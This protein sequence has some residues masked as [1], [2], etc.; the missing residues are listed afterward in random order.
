M[1]IIADGPMVTHLVAGKKCFEKPDMQMIAKG[2]FGLQLHSPGDF[3]A[4]FRNIFVRPL[5]NSFNIPADNA[6]DGNGNKIGIVGIDIRPKNEA[7]NRSAGLLS[8]GLGYDFLGRK[9]PA[10]P[11]RAMPRLALITR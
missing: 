3:T 10:S 9:V 8:P 5:N 6:W 11:A 1:E 2:Q 4:H 7:A